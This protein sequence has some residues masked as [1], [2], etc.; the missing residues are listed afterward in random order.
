[1]TRSVANAVMSAAKP[2]LCNLAACTNEPVP[3]S[4]LRQGFSNIV[5]ILR[6][7]IHPGSLSMGARKARHKDL[8]FFLGGFC[9]QKYRLGA[10]IQIGGAP[11][12]GP[13]AEPGGIPP[14]SARARVP[15]IANL[16]VALRD[17]L[18][19]LAANRLSEI[20]QARVGAA[21]T[22]EY[23]FEYPRN[24]KMVT[25]GEVICRVIRNP[26]G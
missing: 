2:Y 12:L 13:H 19:T 5:F 11:S 4:V 18:R 15:E 16:A 26:R 10:P 25:I 7:P 21:R 23:D 17:T 8:R 14:A 22:Y 20:Q 1:M 3:L 6:P 24:P 9:D